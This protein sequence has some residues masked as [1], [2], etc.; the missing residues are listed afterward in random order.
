MRR[1]ERTVAVV[2]HA[3]FLLA[4][5]HACLDATFEAPQVLLAGEVRAIAISEDFA[6]EVAGH[7]HT[8]PM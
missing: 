2:S 8:N 1:K 6:P 3:H 4:L 7:Y 5:H